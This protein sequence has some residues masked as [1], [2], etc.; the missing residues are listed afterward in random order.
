MNKLSV[1]ISSMAICL[2]TGAS[3][4]QLQLDDVVSGEF[5]PSVTEPIIPMADGEHYLQAEGS[6]I[7]KYSFKTGQVTET[8]LDLNTVKGDRIDKFSGFILAPGEETILLE[9]RSTPVYRHSVSAEYYIFTIR[10]NKL[11]PLSQN[12]P[13][14]SPAY[15][16][17]GHNIAFVRDGNL[18]L[19]KM[20]FG[21]AEIQVTKDGQPGKILNGI[22][23]W[24]YEEEFSFTR[25]FEF[26]ADS[27]M[28]AWIRFDESQVDSYSLPF[29]STEADEG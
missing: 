5:T 13:Q 27:R 26:S 10:N 19:V 1:I 17:D 28:L 3:A 20:L 23:D 25:A 21:N 11:E 15:S 2:S 7:L 22:P 6:Q 14:R 12:G 9:T 18:F 8:V 4:R 24:A 29:F 16:P